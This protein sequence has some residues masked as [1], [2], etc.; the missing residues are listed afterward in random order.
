MQNLLANES[1]SHEKTTMRR[2]HHSI[3]SRSGPSLLLGAFAVFLFKSAPLYWPLTL[4]AFLGYTAIRLWKIRG[5]SLSLIALCG[6]AI[7]VLRS[8]GESLWT[9]VLSTSIAV[10]W[11]LIY[12][13]GQESKELSSLKEEWIKS[14][15]KEK[16]D[17]E[18]Q[19]CEVNFKLAQERREHVGEKLRLSALTAES[20]CGRQTI[21]VLKE[22]LN[23]IREDCQ[24]KT[25]ENLAYQQKNAA[26]QLALDEAKNQLAQLQK[27][28]LEKEDV[29]E[30]ISVNADEEPST[31]EKQK[32]EQIQYQYA[33]LREQFEEKSDALAQARKELFRI[34]N[35]FLSLQKAWEERE[36]EPSGDLLAIRKDFQTL[37]E[38]C[39][40][41]EN[42]TTILQEIV[43]SLI[44]P[45]KRPRSKKSKELLNEQG[46]LS[47][48]I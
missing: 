7:F 5:L 39:I 22:E 3:W 10:S 6:V 1:E 8:G 34:E 16:S 26:V 12:L 9:T 31:E 41:L 47:D 17:L 2:L 21:D 25:E 36:L 23:K 40:D 48:L 13:G 32:L 14:L 19:L 11:L 4:T 42:Q 29:R 38:E 20:A 43:S 33:L 46:L 24:V 35:E 28:L 45:K 15:E 30:P 37:E 18:K 27:Q 44:L